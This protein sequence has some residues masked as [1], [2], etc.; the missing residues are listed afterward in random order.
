MKD[1][2]LSISLTDDMKAKQTAF[3]EYLPQDFI[4]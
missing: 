1:A 3:D 2:V 4:H